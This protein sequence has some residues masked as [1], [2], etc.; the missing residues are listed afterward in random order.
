MMPFLAVQIVFPLSVKVQLRQLG[1]GFVCCHFYW[2]GARCSCFCRV[3]LCTQLQANGALPFVSVLLLSVGSLLAAEIDFRKAKKTL[4][5][6]LFSCAVFSV[7]L[8]AIFDK[9]QIDTSS[10]SQNIPCCSGIV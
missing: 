3:L 9:F 10:Y 2:E 8:D 1:S 4:C 7:V 5:F 6:S